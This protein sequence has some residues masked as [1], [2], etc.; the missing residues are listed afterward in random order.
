MLENLKSKWKEFGEKYPTGKKVIVYG[1][2]ALAT[3]TGGRLIYAAGLEKGSEEMAHML[4]HW[5]NGEFPEETYK[6]LRTTY[7]NPS[8]ASKEVLSKYYHETEWR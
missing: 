1:G 3:I 5:L 7:L 8:I 4:F 2:L 6:I